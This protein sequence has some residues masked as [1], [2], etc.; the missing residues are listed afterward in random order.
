[1]AHVYEVRFKSNMGNGVIVPH[2]YL[3]VLEASSPDSDPSL[4]VDD[5]I[6]LV[7]DRLR[8]LSAEAR[9]S[10]TDWSASVIRKGVFYAGAIQ[11]LGIPRL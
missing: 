9:I 10:F 3:V 2:V 1:M 5:A 4:H 7:Q 8:P 6:D 11:A